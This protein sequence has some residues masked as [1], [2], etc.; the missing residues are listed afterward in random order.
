MV[1][2]PLYDKS[3]I[4]TA[5]LDL[6][7]ITRQKLDFDPAR[8]YSRPDIFDFSVRDQPGIIQDFPKD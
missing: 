7:E 1:S 3:E 4:I 5:E 6:T 2:G 8:H